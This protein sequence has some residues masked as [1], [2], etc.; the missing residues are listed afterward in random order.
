VKAGWQ[1]IR[2]GE[3]VTLNYGKSLGRERRNPE[4]AIPVYGANGIMDWSDDQLTEGPSLVIGRKGSAGEIT[5]VI[6]PFWPSD[7]TYFTSHDE[8]RLSFGFL[9]YA[10]RTL[11]LPSLA[12]GVKPGINRNDVYDLHI[13]LPPLEEQRRIVAILDEAFEGLI[14][15]RANAD[16]NLQNVQELSDTVLEAVFDRL[17]AKTP[18]KELQD[19]CTERGITYGVIKLGDHDP[20]GVPCLRT[21]NVRPLRIDVDGIKSISPELSNEYRRTILEGGEVLVNVRGT[22]GGVAPVSSDMAG[23]NISREVA[24]VPVNQAYADPEF[25]SYFISTRKAQAWLTGV[26]KGVAYKGINLTD[27]RKLML[28]I[29]SVERQREIVDEIVGVRT[30]CLSAQKLYESKLQDIDDLR[31]SLLQSVFAGELT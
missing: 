9:E 20:N 31:Q 13:P 11:N 18:T 27:L 22:L 14:R 2:L 28:P 16:A 10:M 17:P 23:W 24:M 19:V 21:S 26:I 8:A 6:G 12:R 7:V 25:V 29:P 15:A 4:G 30:L 3:V 5:R 1:E